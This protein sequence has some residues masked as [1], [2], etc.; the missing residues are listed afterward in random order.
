MRRAAV[1]LREE[2]G[3]LAA[4]DAG[5]GF[6]CGPLL[7]ARIEP[8]PAGTWRAGPLTLRADGLTC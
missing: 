8:G 6:R 7:V 2:L 4:V 3:A 5:G 1:Y